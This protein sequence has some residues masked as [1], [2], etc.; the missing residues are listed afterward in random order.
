[1]EG[2]YIEAFHTQK[3]G[4]AASEYE[5]A[6]W[7]PRMLT[8]GVHEESVRVAIA[9]GATDAV[10][11]R[12]WARLLVKQYCKRGMSGETV[13]ANLEKASHIWDRIVG[14]RPLPWYAE[15]KASAGA[16]ATLAGLELRRGD[17][18]DP[19]RWSALACGDCCF[20]HL[21]SETLIGSFP[22]SRSQDFS[23]APFLLGSRLS[24]RGVEA[25]QTA[26]G[27]W[28]EGDRLYLMSDA[29]AAWF[30][31][32]CESGAVPWQPLQNV[33]IGKKLSFEHW[34]S[35]LREEK[36]LKND[37]CTLVAIGL[38]RS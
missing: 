29:L 22:I 37:D 36:A 6:F 8:W 5:D 32:S 25:V 20:F 33:T 15:E 11:S 14:R 1:M 2:D 30:L 31:T 4:N 23:N 18:G 28:K 38:G 12:L 9:D 17:N 26:A 7:A 10:Y 19:G 16:Y 3:A 27:T 13:P 21:R 24:T 35:S 34:I